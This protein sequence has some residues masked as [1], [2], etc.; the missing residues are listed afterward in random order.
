MVLKLNH[1]TPESGARC[2]SRVEI[3]G[4][5]VWVAGDLMSC[6]VVRCIGG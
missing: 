1:E 2:N 4:A 6:R 3:P 5:W